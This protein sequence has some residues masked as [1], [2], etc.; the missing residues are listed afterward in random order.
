MLNKS[1]HIFLITTLL[2]SSLILVACG[3]GSSDGSS[4]PV[5]KTWG[6]AELIKT[7][8]AASATFPQ[9]A[10][11]ANGN[12]LA[13]WKEFEGAN[14]NIHSNRYVAGT[15]WGTPELIE[16]DNAGDARPPQVTVDANGN[17]LAV[18][19]QS[20]G[21][22]NNIW[23]N[24]Y[25][26]NSVWGTAGK[27]ETDDVGE[28]RFPQVAFDANG[29]ALAVW[30]QDDGTR[31]N[32][33][34][35]RYVEG[36]GWSAAALIETEVG[37]ANTPQV[38]FDTNGNAFAVWTQ[39]DGSRDSIWSN[40]FIAN[41]GWGTAELLETDDAGTAADP[42][43]AIDING[44]ALAVWSQSDGTR[45]NIYSNRYV[46]GTGWGTAELIE[47]DDAGN[48][49]VPQ[50]AI[51]A[52]GNALAVWYQSDGTR[53]NI[54]SN[55]YLA[56]TGWGTAELIETD[57]AGPAA[58]PQV[59]FD[60]AGNALAVWEQFDGTRNNIWSNRYVTGAGW[61]TAELI[62]TDNAGNASTPQVAVDTN[63]NALAVWS[64]FNGSLSN[65]W[66]NR[67]E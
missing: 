42:Q 58:D 19:E 35:N 49:L 46:A 6:T 65:V 1:S 22:R 32:I 3:G 2:S 30:K 5:A 24:G 37:T 43:V 28:A 36:I 61:G 67:F 55:R 62:E 8:S 51:D 7:D 27:I 57:N 53:L 41:S 45:T 40:R 12:A 54:N 10:F 60:S 9:V 25:I 20:D 31:N 63:G 48:A 52:N 16:T 17:A 56:G 39:F 64:Q 18:W 33:W 11:D 4:E 66:S 44:N 34:S 50:V 26:A 21:T 13:V 23:S 15:G 14:F 38:T 29:N 59:A 47:T